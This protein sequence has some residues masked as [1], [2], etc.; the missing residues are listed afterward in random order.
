[1]CSFAYFSAHGITEWTVAVVRDAWLSGFILILVLQNPLSLKVLF[2]QWIWWGKKKKLK[3]LELSDKQVLNHGCDSFPSILTLAPPP[4]PPRHPQTLIRMRRTLHC[5]CSRG[6][7]CRALV[8]PRGR[9]AGGEDLASQ[10]ATLF[11]PHGSLLWTFTGWQGSGKLSQKAWLQKPHK[12]GL[13]G[14]CFPFHSSI[15]EITVEASKYKVD[16]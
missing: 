15:T 13:N 9:I 3:Q 6:R 5:T 2:N 1:M 16:M 12:S 11:C 10:C 8:Y 4:C 7:V 14:A